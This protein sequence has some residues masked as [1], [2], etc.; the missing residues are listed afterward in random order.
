MQTSIK[1]LL[2]HC[3][4]LC[5]LLHPLPTSLLLMWSDKAV[6]AGRVSSLLVLLTAA[7]FSTPACHC[8]STVVKCLL[9]GA[10]TADCAEGLFT[11]TKR[12]LSGGRMV[13]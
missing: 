2:T 5:R 10:H 12:Q 11:N 7:D 1:P 8:K 13:M 9:F 3:D 6:N 4:D